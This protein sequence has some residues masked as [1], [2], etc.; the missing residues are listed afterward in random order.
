[1]GGREAADSPSRKRRSSLVPICEI[2]VD[3]SMAGL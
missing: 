3:G 2:G 1:M